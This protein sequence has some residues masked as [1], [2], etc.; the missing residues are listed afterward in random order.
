M[1]SAAEQGDT[2]DR[3]AFVIE[4]VKR[5][6]LNV[7]FG[8]S[9]NHARNTALL[10]QPGRVWLSPIYDFAPMKAD[11]EGVIRTV[12]WRSPFEEGGNFDWHGIAT[13][14]ADLVEP[15]QLLNELGTLAR[16]LVGLRERLHQRGVSDRLLTMPVVGLEYL[17]RKLAQW[18]LP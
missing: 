14:L 13:A 3:A 2:F 8:N 1:H 15:E 6:F 12:Q 16:H 5:D 10:K 7:A 11:P 18:G 17:D 4:W 9:D